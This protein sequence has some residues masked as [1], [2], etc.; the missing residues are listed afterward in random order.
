LVSPVTITV[1]GH[2]PYEKDSAIPWH[3]GDDIYFQ[4][5]KVNEKDSDIGSSAVDNVGGIGGFTRSGRLFAPSTL[6]TNAEA[7]AA[8]KAKGK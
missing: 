8:A 2:V 5:R 1:P 7:E 3:Y 6:R 4:G